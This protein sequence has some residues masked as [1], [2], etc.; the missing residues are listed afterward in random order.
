MSITAGTGQLFADPSANQA[1]AYFRS[2]PRALTD[3]LTTVAEAVRQLVNDGDY[4]AIGGFGADRIPTAVAHEIVRQGKQNL[5]FAGHTSTHDFQILCAGNLTGRGQTLAR[6]DNAY[7][8]GL[9]ARGLSP[10]ARRVM[11]SGTVQFTE[12]SN[13]ALAVRL[14]SAA[15]GL[16][17]LPARSMLGTDTFAHSAARTI[18]CP[19][20]GEKLA[21][22]PALYPDVAAIHVHEADRYGNCR[23]RGTTVAD[24]DLARAAK[25]LIITC[26]RVIPN[27][28]IRRDPSLTVIPF[29]CVDAVCEVPFGSY[30]GNMP[31]EYFSD[32]EHLRQWLQVEED[33][34]A[35]KPFLDRYLFGVKDFTEY[36]QLCGGLERMRQLRAQE[37]LLH[38]GR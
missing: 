18:T 31:Y 4:L 33:L 21:A 36:L 2:K 32:E 20:T 23:I 22:L 6:V 30:P 38:R 5:S 26:E 3:K 10:H 24:L 7:V 27:E 35:F 37:L 16:P 12:W 8:V 15:M 14:K 9:E 29:F 25:K 13:Y 11:E 1:R 17:F 19:F 28:E 34:A